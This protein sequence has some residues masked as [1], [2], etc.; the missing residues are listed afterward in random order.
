[1]IMKAKMLMATIIVGLALTALVAVQQPAASGQQRQSQPQGEK[2][3]MMDNMSMDEMMKECR[4]HCEATTNSI[5][6][7]TKTMDEARQSN[8]PAKMRSA[9]DAA[10]TPLAEM[11][12]H[13]SMCMNMMDMMGK[14]HGGKGGMKGMMQGEAG[15]AGKGTKRGAK[16]PGKN[17]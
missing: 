9:L 2:K 8:D 15:A 3:K 7:M 10:Q 4:K 17:P 5:D 14:M 6:Q 11:K 13:M 12:N 1:M 16:K